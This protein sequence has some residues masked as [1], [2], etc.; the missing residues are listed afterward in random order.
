MSYCTPSGFRTL[1]SN[2]IGLSDHCLFKE[3]E[4][5]LVE[6]MVTPAEVAEQLLKKEEANEALEGVTDFLK[7]KKR[8]SERNKARELKKEEDIGERPTEI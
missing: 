7:E 1:A 5:L 3:I 4:E 2:Y 6:A 8:E